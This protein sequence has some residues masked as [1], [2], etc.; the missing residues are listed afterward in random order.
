M[1]LSIASARDV[2]VVE[3]S[4]IE[5][6]NGRPFIIVGRCASQLEIIEHHVEIN[7]CFYYVL[8]AIRNN[9]EDNLIV[10]T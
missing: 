9:K 10:K 7:H 1:R 5:H 8:S 2:N 6:A 3:P 4:S